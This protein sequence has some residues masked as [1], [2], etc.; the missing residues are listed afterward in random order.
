M[1]RSQRPTE[2]AQSADFREALKEVYS[3]GPTERVSE[4]SWLLRRSSMMVFN[5]AGAI[6]RFSRHQRVFQGW[7]RM[8]Q[9]SG[10]PNPRHP[11]QV[12]YDAE[13]EK[14]QREY[15]ALV[16]PTLDATRLGRLSGQVRRGANSKTMKILRWFDELAA[17]GVEKRKR[18]GI[19]ARRIPCD[20]RYARRVIRESRSGR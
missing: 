6:P 2:E 11:L 8:G 10:R 16:G 4:D 20:I 12:K 9:R 15:R 19:I 13:V 17:R 5:H 3:R 18:A 14:Y 1:D 7:Y